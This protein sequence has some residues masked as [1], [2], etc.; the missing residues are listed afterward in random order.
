[1]HIHEPLRSTVPTPSFL[2]TPASAVSQWSIGMPPTS[3]LPT[4]FSE[5]MH[6]THLQH[7][8]FLG[9]YAASMQ[10]KRLK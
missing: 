1:M 6:T 7:A 10:V 2:A 3:L 9:A 8:S 4:A 5:Q